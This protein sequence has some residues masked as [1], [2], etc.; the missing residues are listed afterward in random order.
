MSLC[1]YKIPSA[2]N[3]LILLSRFNSNVFCN[4]F[5]YT[6]LPQPPQCSLR[7]SLIY[8][9][10]CNNYLCSC[11]ILLL[12][13]ENLE[14]RNTELMSY[15]SLYPLISGKFESI[16]APCVLKL[17]AVLQLLGLCWCLQGNQSLELWL[18]YMNVPWACKFSLELKTY[19]LL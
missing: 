10:L 14:E 1:S 6:P 8:I 4:A 2:L 16:S 13:C 9:T 19:G 5:V 12:V 17:G 3:V 18:A 15:F 11:L 7:T